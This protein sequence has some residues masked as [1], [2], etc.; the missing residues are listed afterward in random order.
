M[1]EAEN[2]EF[3]RGLYAA[4]AEGNV[5][6][7]FAAMDEDFVTYQAESLPYGGE[8]R[9]LEAN[10]RM[11]ETISRYVDFASL[12]M[13]HFLAGGDLVLALGTVVWRGLD[14]D[15]AITMPLGEIW[16]VRDGRLISSRP[17]YLDTAT[18][19]APPAKASAV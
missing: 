8:H 13:D 5:A 15:Q 18:M 16:E 4:V 12:K 11:V 10:Q 2:R 17:F 14:G 7:L 1:S 3:V 19:L 9:G 6:P